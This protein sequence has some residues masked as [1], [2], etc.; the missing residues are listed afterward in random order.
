MRYA[1][2]VDTSAFHALENRGDVLEHEIAKAAAK[3][4]NRTTRHWYTPLCGRLYC[5]SEPQAK[6]LAVETLRCAQG[7]KTDVLIS[8]GLI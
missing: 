6:N 4:L 2:L 1:V 7:D 3:Q 5:H 8:C